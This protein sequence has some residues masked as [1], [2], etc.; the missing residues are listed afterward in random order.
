[1]LMLKLLSVN[2]FL[3]DLYLLSNSKLGLYNKFSSSKLLPPAT[4]LPPLRVPRFRPDLPRS[5]SGLASGLWGLGVS[6]SFPNQKFNIQNQTSARERVPLP[7][8]RSQLY[9]IE[10]FRKVSRIRISPNIRKYRRRVRTQAYPTH[11]IFRHSHY[12]IRSHLP[13]HGKL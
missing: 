2:I 13:A 3:A 12:V 1:M 9:L 6:N 5:A 10:S 4:I 11:Q 8:L 7:L